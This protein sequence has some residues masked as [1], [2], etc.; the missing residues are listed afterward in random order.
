MGSKPPEQLVELVGR[1]V[2]DHGAA[3]TLGGEVIARFVVELDSARESLLEI[4]RLGPEAVATAHVN[5]S[6]LCD[7]K[8]YRL[9]TQL[10]GKSIHSV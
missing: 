4:L 6:G 9:L 2:L 5:A 8:R 1:L 10:S 7:E 3:P